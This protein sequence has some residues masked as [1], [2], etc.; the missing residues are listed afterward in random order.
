M[1]VRPWVAIILGL[2]FYCLLTIPWIFWPLDDLMLG[3]TMYSLYCLMALGLSIDITEIVLALLWQQQSLPCNLKCPLR[4]QA[5]IVMTI[6]DDSNQE[7]L[8][9]LESLVDAGH[10]VYLL[11]DSKL[12]IIIHKVLISRIYHIRREFTTGAKAGNLNHWLWNY[13]GEYK[14]VVV[15]DADSLMSLET[16]E[17]LIKTAEYSA[18]ADI[19]IFQAKVEPRPGNRSIFADILSAGARPRL[20]IIERVHVPLGLLLSFGHNQLLRLDAIR[21]IGGFDETLTCEDTVLSLKLAAVGWRTELVDVWSY[22]TDPDSVFAYI[23]RTIRWARQTVELFGRP[24]YEVPLRLK[25]LLCRHLLSYLLPLIGTLLLGVSLWT[26]PYT[27]ESVWKFMVNSLIFEGGYKLYGLTLWPIII[28]FFLYR[29]LR[30]IIAFVEGVSWR[31]FLMG[32]VF[33]NAPYAMLLLPL[34]GSMIASAFGFKVHF[35][36]TNSRYKL[37]YDRNIRRQLL[38]YTLTFVLLIFLVFGAIR[39]P[40]SLLVGFNIIWLGSLLLSPLNLILLSAI[41]RRLI[42]DKHIVN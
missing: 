11:D 12:A 18:N 35:I 20:R 25:L 28:L 19:A 38:H 9:P 5:A 23:R 13:G 15:L 6:C 4:Q 29:A 14:Y 22:D 30:V 17:T 42:V 7:Y 2:G 40:G 16:V 21:A 32:G 8:S 33:G 34:A 31:L 37:N 10:D 39:R 3:M 36:P 41:N 26:G 24:W 27:P 1:K